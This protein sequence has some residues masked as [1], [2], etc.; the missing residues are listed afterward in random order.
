MK[1]LLI[2]CALAIA[3]LSCKKE[4]DNPPLTQNPSEPT[5][6]LKLHSWFN[7]EELVPGETYLNV[8]NYRVNVTGL[9]LYLSD[10]YAVHSDGSTVALTDVAYFDL[11]S[12]EDGIVFSGIPSG[13]YT[14]FGFGLGVPPDMNSPQ[15]PDFSIAV[16]DD[17]HPLSQSN[18]M[19]WVWQSGYRFVIF[20]GKYNTDPD[21]TD[22]LIDGYSYHTGKDESYRTVEFDNL[23]FEVE[24]EGNKV[25]NLDFD[26]DRFY[27]SQNDTINIAVESQ[28]HGT[29]QDL[30]NRV[31]DNIIEAI[32]FRE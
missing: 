19:F 2:I 30:S 22:P 27:Y 18:G 14:G 11:F 13:E 32:S 5:L 6:E 31:S 26:V 28:T 21:G 12:N 4:D 10:V 15:N 24:S 7:L 3:V 20:E 25:I 16:F 1:N 9:K 23:N 8:S 17:N 29:N